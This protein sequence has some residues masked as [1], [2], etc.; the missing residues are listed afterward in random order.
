MSRGLEASSGKAVA[1]DF[2]ATWRRAY[3]LCRAEPPERVVR[4][5]H[6]DAMLLS[7]FLVTRV[8]E[9]A[10]RGLDV[11]DALGREPWLTAAAADVLTELLGPGRTE[12]GWDPPTFLRKA[13][14]REPLE[15][16]ER[17]RLGIRRLTL[18]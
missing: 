8:V 17:D 6:G 7:Q 3:E 1:E 18:G 11:A 12:L 2:T 16:A 10:V 4:T 9:L 13:T 14:G 15:P 5:R